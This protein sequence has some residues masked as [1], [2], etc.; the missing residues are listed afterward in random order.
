MTTGL[1]NPDAQQRETVRSRA[2][3]R[4]LLAGYAQPVSGAQRVPAGRF[5]PF[6]GSVTP[7]PLRRMCTPSPRSRDGRYSPCFRR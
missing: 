7:R 6:L 2:I 1:T 4:A 5:S 3:A